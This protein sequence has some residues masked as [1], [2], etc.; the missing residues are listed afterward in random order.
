MK[1]GKL[2][3]RVLALAF[4]V[5]VL[6]Y[7]LIAVGSAVTDPLSTTLA[8]SYEA[9]EYAQVEGVIVRSEQLLISDY[10]IIQAYVMWMAII[11][12]G[13]NLAADLLYHHLDPRIRLGVNPK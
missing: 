1:Q 4:L 12:V 2:Y 5:A 13:V 11:Y 10:P 8:I 7:I 3:L 6:A 9:S